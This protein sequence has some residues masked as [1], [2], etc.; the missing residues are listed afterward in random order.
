MRL[1]A[2]V[3]VLWTGSALAQDSVRIASVRIA[4]EA[5][6][7]TRLAELMGRLSADSGRG[8]AF[9][10]DPL[11]G[12]YKA[13]SRVEPPGERAQA[14]IVLDLNAW[15]SADP[16]AFEPGV[17]NAFAG[18]FGLAD[19]RRVELVM[20]LPGET[21]RVR[22]DR[23]KE[24]PESTPRHE[25]VLA[26][27]ASS[28]ADPCE[29][30]RVEGLGIGMF[31]AWACRAGLAI[32]PGERRPSDWAFGDFWLRGRS[33]LLRS[34]DRSTVRTDLVITEDLRSGLV[35]RFDPAVKAESLVRASARIVP[36]GIPSLL[37]RDKNVLAQYAVAQDDSGAVVVVAPTE[38]D[39][40]GVL[41]ALGLEAV[42]GRDGP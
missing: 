38:A 33:T 3:L 32:E 39:L 36:S 7:R 26:A 35:F 28:E 16:D 2:M 20:D 17:M 13:D 40:A 37:I 10:F 29:V 19:A 23:R 12:A 15:R 34:L 4:E 42:S 18:S 41:S 21:L 14:E 30:W 6:T 8:V 9:V 5:E 24:N 1:I 25:L 31:T 11:T 22:W 27:R